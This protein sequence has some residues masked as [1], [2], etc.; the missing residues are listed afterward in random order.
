MDTSSAR[1]SEYILA[2]AVAARGRPLRR[3]LTAAERTVASVF[4]IARA[5]M[6]APKCN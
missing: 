2:E 5:G 3:L 6:A 1:R 4:F